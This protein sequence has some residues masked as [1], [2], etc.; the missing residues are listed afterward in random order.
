MRQLGEIKG[1]TRCQTSTDGVLIRNCRAG[2]GHAFQEL[3][4]AVV[5]IPQDLLR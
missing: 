3:Y 4:A 1:A 5:G 2:P